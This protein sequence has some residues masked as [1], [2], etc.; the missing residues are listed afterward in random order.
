MAVDNGDGHQDI[1]A[2]INTVINPV[3][4]AVTNAPTQSHH[5][6]NSSRHQLITSSTSTP[7][8]PLSSPDSHRMKVK[9]H[10]GKCGGEVVCVWG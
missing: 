10:I 9:R 3:I 4:K 1:N 6:I 5:V 8:R 7:T 2:V